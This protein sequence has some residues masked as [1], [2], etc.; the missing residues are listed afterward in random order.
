MRGVVRVCILY[1]PDAF[2]IEGWR[3]MCQNSWHASSSNS[4]S[5]WLLELTRVANWK[6]LFGS[7]LEMIPGHTQVLTFSCSLPSFHT[8]LPHSLLTSQSRS[9]FFL[10][11]EHTRITEQHVSSNPRH[12]RPVRLDL[13][14]SKYLQWPVPKRG[15]LGV[16]NISP[17][18]RIGKYLA[19]STW[20]NQ[21]CDL[22]DPKIRQLIPR[23]WPLAA[24]L[25]LYIHQCI[26]QIKSTNSWDP[27]ER[28]RQEC[29][30]LWKIVLK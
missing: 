7:S 9:F 1:T 17:I 29:F 30:K 24:L 11:V 5:T 15:F 13:I 16:L 26:H 14:S 18:L 22:I 21:R 6:W 28:V 2:S 23:P 27:F 10:I 20:L 4:L 8:T 25:G 19:S 3:A 12:R